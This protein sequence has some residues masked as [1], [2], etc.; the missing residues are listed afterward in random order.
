MCLPE[1]AWPGC[2]PEA[3]LGVTLANKRYVGAG[4]RDVGR[5]LNQGGAT[6]CVLGSRLRLVTA[7]SGRRVTCPN[8]ASSGRTGEGGKD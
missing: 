7:A 4:R 8:S 1:E 2:A 3:E 6:I 5:G